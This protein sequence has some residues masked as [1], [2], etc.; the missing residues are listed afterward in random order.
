MQ[1]TTPQLQSDQLQLENRSAAVA[2]SNNKSRNHPC[3]LPSGEQRI[4]GDTAVLPS[5][6]EQKDNVDIGYVT[7]FPSS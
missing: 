3:Q 7:F 6:K 5:S 2:K 4:K 1:V